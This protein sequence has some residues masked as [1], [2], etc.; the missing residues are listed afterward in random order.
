M[1]RWEHPEAGADNLSS[2]SPQS[3]ISTISKLAMKMAISATQRPTRHW[4]NESQVLPGKGGWPVAGLGSCGSGGRRRANGRETRL[5]PPLST[6]SHFPS[7][8]VYLPFFF[9]FFPFFLF[10]FFFPSPPPPHEKSKFGLS[11]STE[12]FVAIGITTI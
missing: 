7:P 11:P 9:F 3:F 5:D 1:G 10:F 2:P 8:F 12:G 4:V 6:S